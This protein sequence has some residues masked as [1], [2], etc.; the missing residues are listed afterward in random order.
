MSTEVGALRRGLVAAF[1]DIVANVA[2]L[3]LV[4]S[5]SAPPAVSVA[6]AVIG[7]LLKFAISFRLCDLDKKRRQGTGERRRSSSRE[8][9]Q[10]RGL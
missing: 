9:P 1:L 10:Q 6:M 7:A 8:D 4:L 3:F 5:G 2:L